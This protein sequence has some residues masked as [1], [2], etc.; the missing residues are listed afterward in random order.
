MAFDLPDGTTGIDIIAQ[1]IPVLSI[2]IIAQ[3]IPQLNVNIAASAITVDVRTAPGEHVDIDII[4]SIQLNINIAASAITLNVHETGTANVSITSSIQLNVNLAASAITL[5][6]HETGTAN[7]AVTSSITLNIQITGSTINVPVTTA[8]GQHV[9]TDIVSSIQLNINIAAS[10]INVPIDIAAQ[11]VGNVAVNIAASVQL[12]V[13]IAASAINIPVNLAQQTM[14]NVNVNIASSI[15]V[16]MSITG[17]TINVPVTTAMGQHVDVDITSSIT[18]NITLTG[19]TITLNINIQS[20]TVDLNIKTSGGVNI[21]I[22]QLTQAAYL[23]RRSTLSNSGTYS[24]E[25]ILGSDDCR[26]KFFPRGARGFIYTI[27]AYC[28]DTAAAG[29]T[30]TVYL[31]PYIG[32]GY[33]YSATITV[34][35]G[36]A[37]AWRSATFNKMWNYDALFIWVSA[38]N[39]NTRVQYDNGTPYDEFRS[40]DDGVT[41]THYDLRP[42]LRAVMKAE[43]VG[44]LPVSGTVNTIEI[45]TSVSGFDYITA[46]PAPGGGI[47]DLLSTVNGIGRLTCFMVRCV[48]TAGEVNADDMVLGFVIDGTT[49]EIQVAEFGGPVGGGTGLIGPVSF[50]TYDDVNNDYRFGFNF[51]LKFLRTLRIYA[52]NNALAGNTYS[53]RAL[54][55]YE[56]MR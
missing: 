35:A 25:Y 53:A 42:H 49:Y 22:D 12:N 29:G 5:N 38:S 34:P 11:S 46:A 47:A 19:S 1:T 41:W 15:T 23:E 30:I 55:A 51:V 7:V 48:Q 54:F 17:S 27:D 14:G 2:D 8:V 36:G 45:P 33:I 16:N 26:G 13:N 21:V 9:D 32:A 56:L 20:Q 44:D 6:V 37:R 39:I 18:L 28:R 10:G 43:T 52:R 31:S 40:S 50:Q 4:S 24:G 3:T